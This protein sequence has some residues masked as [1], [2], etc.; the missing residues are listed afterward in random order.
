MGNNKSKQT[1]N[2]SGF[3]S[4]EEKVYAH[5]RCEQETEPVKVITTTQEKKESFLHPRAVEWAVI[6]DGTVRGYVIDRANPGPGY[7]QEFD[8]GQYR[9]YVC[10]G[11]PTKY[12]VRDMSLKQAQKWLKEFYEKI[13]QDN[14]QHREMRDAIEIEKLRKDN[15]VLQHTINQQLKKLRRAHREQL[16]QI[17]SAHQEQLKQILSAHREQIKQQSHAA[18]TDGNIASS[19]TSADSSDEYTYLYYSEED[20]TN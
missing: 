1:D 4:L 19:H 8:S 2:S 14:K 9:K 15:A 7:V 12:F 6:V 20:Q 3:H 17:R 10:D 16:K 5:E 11:K 13:D 18:P